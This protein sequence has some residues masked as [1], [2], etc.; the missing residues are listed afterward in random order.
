[1]P[2]TRRVIVFTDR[3]MR[4]GR[5]QI[6]AYDASE[7]ALYALFTLALALHPDLPPFLAVDN[8]GYGMHPWLV[9]KLTNTFCK[10]LLE[11]SPR[12]Q[13]L[14]TTHDPMVLDGLPSL[15]DP[16]VRLFAVER[17]RTHATVVRPVIVPEEVWR[18][19]EEQGL[20]LSDLWVQG[21]L[22]AVPVLF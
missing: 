15:L 14:L 12:R 11:E 16:R 4:R 18:M 2:T 13:V 8:F 20:V 22:G 10:L 5:N 6:T 19:R 1:L 3:R 7:G 9:R 17:D 21:W